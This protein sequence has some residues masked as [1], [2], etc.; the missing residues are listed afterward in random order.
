MNTVN[1]FVQDTLAFVIE[2]NNSLSIISVNDPTAPFKVGEI[3]GDISDYFTG[4]TVDG[5]Y[6]YISGNSGM[7]SDIWPTLKIYDIRNPVSPNLL[8]IY[9]DSTVTYSTNG[10]YVALAGN[11]ALMTTVYGLR[12]IDVSDLQNPI[13]VSQYETNIN[14]GDVQ[15]AGHLV[16]VTFDM[17]NCDRTGLQIIDVSDATQLRERGYLYLSPAAHADPKLSISGDYVYITTSTTGA[18]SASGIHVIDVSDPGHPVE[19][20]FLNLPK[21]KEPIAASDTYLYVATTNADTI[22]ILD[23]SD[24]SALRMIG[25]YGVDAWNYGFVYSFLVKGNYLYVGT[26]SGLLILDR[27]N[28]ALLSMAGFYSLKNVSSSNVEGIAVDGNTAYLAT[29]YGLVAV[30]ISDVHNP[31]NRAFVSGYYHD[32][33]VINSDVYGA[34]NYQGVKLFNWENDTTLT[35]KDYYN[36]REGWATQL[37]T[38]GNVLYANYQGL[39]VLQKGASTAIDEQPQPVARYF[40]LYQN[41]P[42]PF[43]PTTEIRYYLPRAAQVNISIYNVLGQKVKTLINEYRPAGLQQIRFNGQNLSSG[44]YFYHL[45]VNRRTV[46]I[47]KM[48]LLR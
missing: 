35:L 14:A 20:T 3:I 42:N 31:K 33:E 10:E 38:D 45:K 41:Y 24:P 47:R 28:G 26:N 30:D 8:G 25:S 21:I 48:M 34:D 13:Q 22:R 9:S 43:N 37:A 5:R 15:V 4:V 6:L 27:Q 1:L 18:D 12:I 39:L 19:T 46:A 40:E 29:M 2:N 44:V 11:Y 23:I 7:N 36:T 17:V 16:Y 32:V